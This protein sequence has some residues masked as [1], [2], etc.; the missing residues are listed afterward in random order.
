M[1]R[2]RYGLQPVLLTREW[3]V[4]RLRTDMAA[5]AAVLAQ[6]EQ[7]VAAAH[8]ELAAAGEQWLA[9]S[10]AGQVLGVDRLV[11]LAHYAADR[12]RQVAVCQAALR[13]AEDVRAEL[14][15]QLAAAQR[16]LEGL[17][18]HRA[19]EREAYWQAKLSGECR[20]ADELWL[21]AQAGKEQCE[22]Q[23]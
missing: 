7:A 16:A 1:T 4:D 12:R 11:R 19:K 15:C 20:A 2:F 3:E 23:S 8:A 21:A 13:Q 6:A 14:A 5:H 22:H 9:A 17:Q 18:E 10:A